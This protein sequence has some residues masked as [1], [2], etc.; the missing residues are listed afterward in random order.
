[1]RI[2][3]S[4]LLVIIAKNLYSQFEND[5]IVLFNN[6]YPDTLR[7]YSVED[8]LAT[9]SLILNIDYL[10][11]IEYTIEY[12]GPIDGGI[13]EKSNL[14]TNRIKN[15]LTMPAVISLKFYIYDIKAKNQDGQIINIPSQ[16]FQIKRKVLKKKICKSYLVMNDSNILKSITY[17]DTV[18]NLICKEEYLDKCF[19]YHPYLKT[20]IKYDE[21]NRIVNLKSLTGK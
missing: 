2:I 8:I 11:I 14:L 13:N 6:K 19:K 7:T 20:T 9:D 17:F 10:R 21:K 5:T 12:T 18:G 15:Y 1:M 16:Y 3:L 4:I